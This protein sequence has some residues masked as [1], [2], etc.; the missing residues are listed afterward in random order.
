MPSGP[1]ISNAVL[2]KLNMT[3][4]LPKKGICGIGVDFN[5]TVV[6][7]RRWFLT[8]HILVVYFWTVWANRHTCVSPGLVFKILLLYLR[9]LVVHCRRDEDVS[10]T[11]ARRCDIG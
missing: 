7:E 4:C 9:H 6:M 5:F 11:R 1:P 10:K 3:Q 2:K 8:T